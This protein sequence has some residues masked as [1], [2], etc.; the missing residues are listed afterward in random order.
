MYVHAYLN[1][2]VKGDNH[3][4]NMNISIAS[5]WYPR[6]NGS[7]LYVSCLYRSTNQDI[8]IN[9][10]EYPSLLKGLH[11]ARNF[12]EM[13]SSGELSH[14][15]LPSNLN[16]FEIPFLKVN[17]FVPSLYEIGPVA[18]EKI[19]KSCACIFTILLLFQRRQWSFVW[20]NL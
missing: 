19:C 1:I 11:F 2:N 7:I 15:S 14:N 5:R 17:Y 16:K 4:M 12:S 20:S 13:L 18:L 9:H 3:V 10:D 8:W 6:K